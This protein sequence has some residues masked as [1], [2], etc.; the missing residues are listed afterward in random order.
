MLDEVFLEPIKKAY[1]LEVRLSEEER[2][3]LKQYAKLR[4]LTMSKF[5]RI[6]ILEKI[7]RMKNATNKS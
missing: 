7:K 5:A 6:A 3:E 4:N 1:L 2:D